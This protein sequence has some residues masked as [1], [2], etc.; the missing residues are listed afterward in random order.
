MDE[1]PILTAK[2][3]TNANLF[4]DILELYAAQGS[5]ILDMTYGNGVFWKKATISNYILVRNDL[6][7]SKD[8]DYCYDFRKFP[9]NWKEKFDIVVYDPPY[10]YVGGFKTF[11]ASVD[12][13]YSNKQRAL[14]QGIHGVEAVDKMYMDGMKEAWRILKPKGIL[15]AKCMDQV[16]SGRLEMPHM[17]Y[18]D[19]WKSL[20]GI[21][22]DFFVLVTNGQPTMRHKHQIHAR[23]NH[24]YFMVLQKANKR[25]ID[26]MAESGYP[27]G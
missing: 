25:S 8:V 27:N 19:Y 21:V 2:V 20:G 11:K 16:M 7:A 4:P 17:R 9:E 10:L 22:Q 18:I 23:R 26:K 3:G 6:D 12:K 13:G 1:K 5:W 15:I 24:S 14:E